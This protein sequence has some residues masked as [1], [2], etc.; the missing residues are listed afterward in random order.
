MKTFNDTIGN[1]TRDLPA[2]SSVPQP[3]AP[4]RAPVTMINTYYFMVYVFQYWLLLT[5]VTTGYCRVA[6]YFMFTVTT[7]LL[8]PVAARSKAQVYG[9]SPAE[10]V[11][12]NP[13][14]AWMFVCCECCVLSGRGLCDELITR[15][16]ESYRLCCVIVCDIETSRMRRSWPALGRSAIE[17]NNY[18][19]V[20]VS[21]IIIWLL[22]CCSKLLLVAINY[23]A[24]CQLL[25]IQR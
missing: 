7:Q 14:G 13:T 20:N 12:S 19:V 18:Y 4:P 23:C 17:T 24:Y 10:I 6:F 2:C 22:Y 25:Y 3:T 11:G 15:P 5:V 9:C 16:E 8:V 1:R 21:M